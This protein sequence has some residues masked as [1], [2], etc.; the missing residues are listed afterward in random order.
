MSLHWLHYEASD[1]YQTDNLKMLL[2]LEQYLIPGQ[3]HRDLGTG[4]L[5]PAAQLR[6][7]PAK[8]HTPGCGFSCRLEENGLQQGTDALCFSH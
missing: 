6:D 2:P 3:L 7:A 1:T 5:S 8:R 4:V